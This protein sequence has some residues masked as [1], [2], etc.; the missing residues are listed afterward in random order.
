MTFYVMYNKYAKNMWQYKI[1]N[2]SNIFFSLFSMIYFENTK[3]I[4]STYHLLINM[5][6]GINLS[7]Y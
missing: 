4:L 6:N 3:F 7:Y 5:K 2:K 1:C